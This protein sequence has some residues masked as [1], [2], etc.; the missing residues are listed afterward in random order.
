MP[1]DVLWLSQADIDS[2][3]PTMLEIMDE[4]ER[5]FVAQGLGELCAGQKAGLRTERRAA[6]LMG[7]ALDDVMTGRLVSQKALA[8]KVGTWVQL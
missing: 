5:C 6:V 8:R 2:L 7:I 4:V 3:D 1:F